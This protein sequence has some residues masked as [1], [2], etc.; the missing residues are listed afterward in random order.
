MLYYEKRTLWMPD[1]E[2][3]SRGKHG[4]R[5]KGMEDMMRIHACELSV[6]KN[7]ESSLIRLVELGDQLNATVHYNFTSQRANLRVC[8]AE[9]IQKIC[10]RLG[11]RGTI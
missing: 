4:E 1:F 9:E 2:L 11:R 5:F 10:D 8:S 6:T 7:D 3:S